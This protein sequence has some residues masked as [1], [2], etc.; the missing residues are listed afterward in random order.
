ML[1][2]L[3]CILFAGQCANHG[4]ITAGELHKVID[5]ALA[6]GWQPPLEPDFSLGESRA[7]PRIEYY[8]NVLYLSST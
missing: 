3:L 4:T 5:R 1:R 6:E 8:R 7:V 2:M